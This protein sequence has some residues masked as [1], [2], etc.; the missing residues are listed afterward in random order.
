MSESR[1]SMRLA[2]YLPKKKLALR[3]AV[4]FNVATR[5]AVPQ[6]AHSIITFPNGFGLLPIKIWN[7]LFRFPMKLRLFQ[8][9]LAGF[10]HR[11]DYAKELAL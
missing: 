4:V 2:R 3:Q 7:W 8:K 1:I 5:I 11:T 10:A 9:Y 6:V